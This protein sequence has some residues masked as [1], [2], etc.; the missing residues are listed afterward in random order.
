MEVQ[1]PVQANISM[2][3]M[4][5]LIQVSITYH[6]RNISTRFP[7]LMKLLIIILVQKESH[8]SNHRVLNHPINPPE[9]LNRLGDQQNQMS[10]FS[11]ILF[12]KMHGRLG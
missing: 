8:R 10:N 4:I 2:R 5:A 7:A 9:K 11:C 3:L 1:L 12:V 6:L